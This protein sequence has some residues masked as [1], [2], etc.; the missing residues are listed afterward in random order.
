[1]WQD[2][3]LNGG[4]VDAD[5]KPPNGV[6]NGL[7]NPATASLIEAAIQ[8]QQQQAFQNRFLNSSVLGDLTLPQLT[9]AMNS[10][11]SHPLYNHGVCLWPSCE[12][13]CDSY[14]TFVHH[15]SSVHKL[16]DRSTAQCR[17]QMQVKHKNALTEIKRIIQL[18]MALFCSLAFCVSKH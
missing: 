8:Q 6:R 14:M 15:L 1:M 11:P 9:A 16:D 10:Q 2:L 7:A 17:V 18:Y 3:V 13:V 12:S 5:M 4:S